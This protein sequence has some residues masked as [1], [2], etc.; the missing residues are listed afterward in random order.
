MPGKPKQ[1]IW[2]YSGKPHPVDEKHKLPNGDRV[3]GS[4]TP[5]FDY[6]YPKADYKE[7]E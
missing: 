7:G 4:A 6:R 1:H 2:P 3:H 5:G